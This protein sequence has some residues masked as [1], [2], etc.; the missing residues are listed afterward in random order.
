MEAEAAAA[1][2]AG[3]AKK[4]TKLRNQVVNIQGR[5]EKLAAVEPITHSL[6]HA[7]R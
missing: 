7:G 5:V 1:E 6:K 2:E 4:V 3:Q